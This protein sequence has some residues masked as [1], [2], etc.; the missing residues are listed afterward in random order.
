MWQC[1]L[2]PQGGARGLAGSSEPNTNSHN[3]MKELK[4]LNSK[5]LDGLFPV[6]FDSIGFAIQ[7][8]RFLITVLIL[9]LTGG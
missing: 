9:K 7:H 1:P 3:Q 8:W 4:H 5:N 2:P 6:M